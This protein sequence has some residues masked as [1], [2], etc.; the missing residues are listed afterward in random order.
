MR[1]CNSYQDIKTPEDEEEEMI[2]EDIYQDLLDNALEEA[3][4]RPISPDTKRCLRKRA[5]EIFTR[6][7]WK[8]ERR[9]D[10]R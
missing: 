4:G 3:D 10:G 2:I 6:K 9:R 7:R 1:S 8:N 5:K